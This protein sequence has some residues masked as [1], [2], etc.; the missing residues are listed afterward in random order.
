MITTHV[1][2]HDPSPPMFLSISLSLPT[3]N[4][5]CSLSLSLS[6]KC[7]IY[8]CYQIPPIMTYTTFIGP[9]F[10]L[11]LNWLRKVLLGILDQ[12]LDYV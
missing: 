12:F 8:M 7:S 9:S 4:F 6:H 11:I 2:Y 1:Q 5:P 10:S 3:V